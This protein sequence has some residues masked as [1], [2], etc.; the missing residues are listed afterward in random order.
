M[1]VIQKAVELL[2]VETDDI[3]F[4]VGCGDGRFVCALGAL[5][6]CKAVIGVEIDEQRGTEAKERIVALGLEGSS[7]IIIG[8]A[9]EQDYSNGTAF[10]LYL[11]PR[12]LRILLGIIRKIPRANIKVVT[13]MSPFGE[14][15]EPDDIVKVNV[16]QHGADSS[17]PLYVYNIKGSVP[18]EGETLSTATCFPALSIQAAQSAAVGDE[19]ATETAATIPDITTVGAEAVSK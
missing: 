4:D 3:V 17:W 11:V 9:L 13:Y 10:F 6:I 12:G 1:E 5:A 8:N 19:C 18:D 14:G 2:H 15:V 16:A 7:Q